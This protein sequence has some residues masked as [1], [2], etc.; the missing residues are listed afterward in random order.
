MKVKEILEILKTLPQD[1]E[2]VV[3]IDDEG[4]GFRRI[5]EGWVSVEK[6]TDNL[7]MVATE[8]IDTEYDGID[9]TDFV[10]IG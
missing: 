9:L 4:N 10:C 5:P 8:D 1:L 7:Y 2:V 3:A 6:F